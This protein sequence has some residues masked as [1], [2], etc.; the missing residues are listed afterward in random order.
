[1]YA[2][3]MEHS[4]V[5]T[6]DEVYL[7]RLRKEFTTLNDAL[8]QQFK[9]PAV[10]AREEY[11]NR[12]LGGSGAASLIDLTQT[13]SSARASLIDHATVWPTLV[14]A[15]MPFLV[16]FVLR[17]TPKAESQCWRLH[18]RVPIIPGNLFKAL[19][20]TFDGVL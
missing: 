2:G 5:K 20:C 12:E 15:I 10:D 19:Y 11:N 13:F 16:R 4:P 6:V 3:T 17:K 9:V 8:V 1:M 7:E 18:R 14:S